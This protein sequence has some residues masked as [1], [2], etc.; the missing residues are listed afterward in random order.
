MSYETEAS[1]NA[2]LSIEEMLD[3]L[4]E[5][6]NGRPKATAEAVFK[7]DASL[8][9]AAQQQYSTELLGNASENALIA[10]NLNPPD[11]SPDSRALAVKYTKPGLCPTPL[12]PNGKAPILPEFNTRA[13]SDP[14]K[15]FALFSDALGEPR[16]CNIGIVNGALLPDGRELLI[17]DPDTKER[18]G[19]PGVV[20]FNQRIKEIQAAIGCPLPKTVTSRSVTT[21]YRGGALWFSA[22][23]GTFRGHKQSFLPHVDLPIQAV[24]P[25]STIDGRAYEWEPGHGLGEIRLAEAPQ[26][27]IDA[28][29]VALGPKT[30]TRDTGG[31]DAQ[32]QP[33]EPAYEPDQPEDIEAMRKWLRDPG[34]NGAPHAGDGRSG[35]GT[36]INKCFLKFNPTRE[37]VLDVLTEPGGWNETKTKEPWALDGD[38]GGPD[39]NLTKYVDDQYKSLSEAPGSHGRAKLEDVF[40]VEDGIDDAAADV[41]WP[42]PTPL[43]DALAPV[44]PFDLAFL[45]GSLAPWVADIA[46]RMQCPLD[47][48]A[49][50][51][52]VALGSV[53]GRKVA[54]RPRRNDDWCEHPNLWGMVV[55]DPGSKK[56]PAMDAAMEPLSK[57]EADAKAAGRPAWVAYER[58]CEGHKMRK[59][60]AEKKFQKA[61]L[62]DPAAVWTAPAAPTAPKKRRYRVNDAT[63]EALGEILADNPNG[64]LSYRDELVTLL[65]HLDREENATARGFYL[66]AW[67]GKQPYEFDRIGRGHLSIEAVCLSALGST[68]PGKLANY[69]RRSL[70]DDGND[71]MLQRFQLLVWPDRRAEW[72]EIDR[73]PDMAARDR[74]TQAFHRL[75]KFGEKSPFEEAVPDFDEG[76]PEAVAYLRFDERAQVVFSAW[77]STLERRLRSDDLP[78][79]LCE[80]FSKYRGLVPALALLNHL[81]DG[82]PGDVS[83]SALDRAIAFVGYL[84]THARRAYGAGPQSEVAAAKAILRRITKGDLAEGFTARDVYRPAWA[85]LSKAQVLPALDL[86]TDYDWLRATRGRSGGRPTVTYAINPVATGE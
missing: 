31:V 74:A 78:P 84:E 68:Q 79:H 32:R 25:G 38:D 43:P 56:S 55:G 26:A 22:P 81:A 39:G 4:P 69:V 5:N 57:L 9:G 80:H 2:A 75:D 35:T 86:L 1:G 46:E 23:R 34:P 59:A 21:G 42:A 53:L 47:F 71:G 44:D 11:G 17:V 29:H 70:S 30:E 3:G 40:D 45:P 50:A 76:Q 67:N 8:G 85:G 10:A 12:R 77:L 37:T 27:L 54:I 51:A 24:A 20:S 15:V 62:L 19:G 58:A 63:Y 49:I 7:H 41:E 64:V 61:L 66:T 16:D 6:D 72:K 28:Y 14:E 36:I 52:I 73:S 83:T 60:V 82:N 48:V 33:P 18:S 13:T 65:K